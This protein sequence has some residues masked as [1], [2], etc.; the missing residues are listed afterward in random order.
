MSTNATGKVVFRRAASWMPGSNPGT[1]NERDALAAEGCARGRLSPDALALQRAAD[2]VEHL[3][4]L[5][6]RRHRPGVAVGDLL[7]GAAEDFA[8]TRLRQPRDDDGEAERRHRAD[9]V[10]HE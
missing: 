2:L 3:G 1:T 9:L 8:G 4:V 10:A 6:G 7:D 5:D